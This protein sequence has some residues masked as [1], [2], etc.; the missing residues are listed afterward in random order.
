MQWLSGYR[1]YIIG[2]GFLIGALVHFIDGNTEAA[3]QKVGEGFA[4]I[5]L[6][7]GV[8]KLGKSELLT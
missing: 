7:A 8:S 4:L 1:T 2:V 3:L 5:F 6:R